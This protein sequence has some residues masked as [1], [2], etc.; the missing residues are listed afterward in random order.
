[1]KILSNLYKSSAAA[2]NHTLRELNTMKP[3]KHLLWTNDQ[4]PLK[5]LH[6]TEI[7]NSRSGL[8]HGTPYAPK[9]MQEI[10]RLFNLQVRQT[11]ISLDAH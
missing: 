3:I 7:L 11:E 2:F 8:L 6:Y 1:M 9:F 10:K 4:H 5:N